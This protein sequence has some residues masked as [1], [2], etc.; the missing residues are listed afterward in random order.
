MTA[1]THNLGLWTGEARR[2]Q[3]RDRGGR[4]VC[5]RHTPERLA[6]LATAQQ[7]RNELGLPA[8][9][10]LMAKADKS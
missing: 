8:D 4:F 10:R 2:F 7:I 6:V 1:D 9:P 5:V 3:P